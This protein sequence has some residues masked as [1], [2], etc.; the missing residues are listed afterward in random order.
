MVVVLTLLGFF[1]TS[2]FLAALTT[3]FLGEAFTDVLATL[4][5]LAVALATLGF[6]VA[7]V[8][9]LHNHMHIPQINKGH[10]CR[11]VR[12]SLHQ[13]QSQ[14]ERFAAQTQGRGKGDL[15]KLTSSHRFFQI[16][17][18]KLPEIRNLR[19]KRKRERE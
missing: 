5:S 6:A 13:N 15:H 18:Q 14:L 11:G 3:F 17:K 19:D 2:A 4:A 9:V 10:I 12:V 8:F 1:F 7:F 16:I